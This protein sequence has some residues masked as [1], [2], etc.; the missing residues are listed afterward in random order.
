M[1]LCGMWLRAIISMALTSGAWGQ[2]AGPGTRLASGTPFLGEV[3]AKPE[4]LTEVSAPLWG[5]IE[6]GEGVFEGARVHRGQTLATLTLELSAAERLPLDDR[7]IQIDGFL[8]RAREKLRFALADYQR[9]VKIRAGDP[10]FEEEVERRKS[11][12]ESALREF[13]QLSRQRATQSGVIKSRDPKVVVVEA[14]RSGYITRIHFIPGEVNPTDEFRKLFTLVDLST[15]LVRVEVFENDLPNWRNTG[16]VE[17]VAP[18]LGGEAFKGK[19]LAFGD[20]VDP[21]TRSIPVFFEVQNREELLKLG[22]PVRVRRF[23]TE[24]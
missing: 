8:E 16:R 15:V 4:L 1:R 2:G 19:F 5:R 24:P 11:L 22:L 21:S 6:L 10:N 18:T 13:E 3:V 14:P 9:A 23:P 7:T 20:Q 17:V 12:Y